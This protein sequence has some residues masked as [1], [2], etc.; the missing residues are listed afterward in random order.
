VKKFDSLLYRFYSTHAHPQR[1]GLRLA[2][3]EAKISGEI[4]DGGQDSGLC[5]PIPIYLVS[6]VE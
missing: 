3:V 5:W 4:Q 2:P 6:H 1:E